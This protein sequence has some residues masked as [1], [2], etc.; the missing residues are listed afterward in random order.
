ME[1]VYENHFV[2]EKEAGKGGIEKLMSLAHIN[3]IFIT[4]ISRDESVVFG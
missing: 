2:G 1:T 3:H 4:L